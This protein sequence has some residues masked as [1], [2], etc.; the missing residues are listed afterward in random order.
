MNIHYN[1]V[2]GN[3]KSTRSSEIDQ[4][5]YFIRTQDLQNARRSLVSLFDRGEQVSREIIEAY[6]LLETA[7]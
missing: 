7:R 1:A 3:S 4:L 2:D 6:Q 5:V